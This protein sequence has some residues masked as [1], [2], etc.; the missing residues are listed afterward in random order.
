MQV[1][2][3][4][5]LLVKLVLQEKAKWRLEEPQME[6]QKCQDTGDMIF[7]IARNGIWLRQTDGIE[8]YPESL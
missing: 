5:V 1:E 4:I 3:R 2:L 6:E 7:Y 8:S